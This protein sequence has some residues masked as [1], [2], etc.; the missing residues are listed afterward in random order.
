VTNSQAVEGSV[1][2]K[3]AAASKASAGVGPEVTTTL[4]ANFNVKFSKTWGDSEQKSL[5]ISGGSTVTLP[6]ERM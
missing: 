4:E 5:Q 3:W 2:G 1:G 6:A